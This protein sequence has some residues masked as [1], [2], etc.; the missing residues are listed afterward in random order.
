M[1]ERVRRSFCVR[2][3]MIRLTDEEG[4]P[5]E[6]HSGAPIPWSAN[7]AA[8]R[9]QVMAAS[10]TVVVPDIDLEA[11]SVQAASGRPR[12]RFYAGIPLM[13]ETGRPFGVLSLVHSQPRWLSAVHVRAFEDL[14]AELAPVAARRCDDITIERLRDRLEKQALTIRAQAEEMAQ[15]RGTFER[16][17]AGARVGIWECA[18]HDDGLTWTDQVFDLF[19]IPR[20]ARLAR[21]TTLDCYTQA[22]REVL[23]RT[24]S[25]AIAGR[26]GFRLDTEIVT[27]KGRRRWIRLTA[28]TDCRDGVPV[29][30][31][32]MKQDITEQTLL[33]ERTRYLA[34]FDVMTGLANRASFEARLADLGADRRDR[35]PVAALLLVDLDGFKRINDGFGHALGDAC[36]QEAARRLG[37]VCT[38]ADLVA[39]IGGDEF[40]VLLGRGAGDSATEVLADAIVAALSQP[41]QCGAHAFRIG[42]SVGIAPVVGPCTPSDLFTQA[43]TALYAA[44]AAGRGT[45]RIFDAGMTNGERGGMPQPPMPDGER[46]ALRQ[47]H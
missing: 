14:A 17:A 23:E 33:L 31:F 47:A 2:A 15:G 12:I 13:S 39:R 16:A 3:A 6:F 34:E 45:F 7:P 36:L 42:A 37:T 18:L 28:A 20:G 26:R 32:G 11:D 29:R 41:M 25:A 38:G 5:A 22:S 46:R 4:R 40:A 21:H 8:C 43:D 1:L 27:L 19:E 35:A 30:L 10:G 24:R 9:L 44:K